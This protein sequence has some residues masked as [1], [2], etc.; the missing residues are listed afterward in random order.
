MKVN[1][2]FQ[3]VKI[4]GQDS[5]LIYSAMKT[6]RD[7]R[8]VL[9]VSTRGRP[10]T[11]TWRAWVPCYARCKSK[12]RKIFTRRPDNAWQQ[13]NS[14]RTSCVRRKLNWWEAR[15]ASRRPTRPRCKHL[16]RELARTLPSDP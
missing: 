3:A 10:A 13:S 16:H 7:H 8:A 14:G 12:P 9:N 5:I 15:G 6:S 4:L 1:Y 2:Q 11:T